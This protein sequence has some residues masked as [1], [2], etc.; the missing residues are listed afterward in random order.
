MPTQ[1]EWSGPTNIYSVRAGL[2]AAHDKGGVYTG[3]ESGNLCSPVEPQ[4]LCALAFWEAP[5][6]ELAPMRRVLLTLAYKAAHS[7]YAF[8]WS[9]ALMG[10]GTCGGGG[11]INLWSPIGFRI[12]WRLP[13]GLRLQMNRSLFC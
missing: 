9:C 3:A 6:M 5:P 7:I 1:E 11:S 2:T 4:V 8:Q 10:T 12:L 13:K